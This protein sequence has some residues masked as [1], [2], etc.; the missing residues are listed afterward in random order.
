MGFSSLERV[1]LSVLL[2]M[3]NEAARAERCIRQVENAVNCFSSSY[4][5]V[6]VEDGSTDGTDRIAASLTKTNPRIKMLHFP[7]RLG[8]GKAIKNAFGVAKGDII[9]LLDADLATRLDYLPLL[10][11]TAEECGGMVAGSRLVFGSSVRRPISRTLLSLV[12]N[13]LV[14]LLFH[15][16][17]HDH[18]C[19]FK[20]FSRDLTMKL[21]EKTVADGF[22]VDTEFIVNAKKL[23]YPVTEIPVVWA[24]PRGRGDSKVRPLREALKMGFELLQLRLSINR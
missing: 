6:V 10:V 4:E 15:D 17:V 13:F 5:I 8:K 20:A 1:K 7:V 18:Q 2:P 23:G 22:F 9:V 21:R 24:E 16:G 19:G 3:Y 14:R 11:K 12:Y